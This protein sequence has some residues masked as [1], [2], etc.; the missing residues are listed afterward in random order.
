MALRLRIRELM[1][2]K[3]RQEGRKITPKSLA[4]VIGVAPN[5]IRAY[6]EDR[7]VRPDLRILG[8]LQ[9]YFE[10][11]IEDLFEY[12]EDDIEET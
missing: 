6:V 1:A 2:E 10:C 5:T 12:V 4:E 9:D 7:A 11:A 3:A 8:K